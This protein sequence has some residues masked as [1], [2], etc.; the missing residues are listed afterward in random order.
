M[1]PKVVLK[2]STFFLNQILIKRTLRPHSIGR[3]TIS[4]HR[5]SIQSQ[6]GHLCLETRHHLRPSNCG[7][8]SPYTH[9]LSPIYT[10]TTFSY[11]IYT[12]TLNH[13]EKWA[14][15]L[16]TTYPP[17]QWDKTCTLTHH[18][19]LAS[20]AHETSFR[21]LSC[22]YRF[23]VF[24]YHIYPSVPDWCWHSLSHPGTMNHIWWA[25]S[26]IKALWDQILMNYSSYKHS[27]PNYPHV[28]HLSTMPVC[29]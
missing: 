12:L 5:F 10:H 6:T 26:P 28:V 27:V 17:E 11:P 4:L 20:K 14:T 16:G 8:D 22:W 24:L 3:N 13:V 15:E 29:P 23:C 19:S 21:I 7:G 2:S 25:C 1:S 9:P 18:L